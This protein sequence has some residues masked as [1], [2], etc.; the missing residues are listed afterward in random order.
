MIATVEVRKIIIR[1]AGSE[2]ESNSPQCG[3]IPDKPVHHGF[4][5]KHRENAYVLR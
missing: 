4:H 5:Q 2:T 3:V 1:P